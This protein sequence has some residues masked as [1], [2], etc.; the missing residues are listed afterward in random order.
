[1]A[2]RW[3]NIQQYKLTFHASKMPAEQNNHLTYVQNKK[4]Y[5]SIFPVTPEKASAIPPRDTPKL[6]KAFSA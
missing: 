3:M 5:I 6:R 2:L 1:M 4:I